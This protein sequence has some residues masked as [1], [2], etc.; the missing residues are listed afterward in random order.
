MKRVWLLGSVSAVCE[1][2]L[3]VVDLV[4]V[5][6]LELGSASAVEYLI[7]P[8]GEWTLGGFDADTGLSGRKIIIDNYG[9]EIPVGEQA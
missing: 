5:I 6:R 4:L 3:V 2:G 9:P 8:A 7:N 1:K